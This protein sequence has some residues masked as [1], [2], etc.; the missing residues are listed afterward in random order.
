MTLATEH[1]RGAHVVQFYDTDDALVARVADHLA[2][3]LRDGEA[4]VIVA[5][6]PHRLAF[7]TKMAGT[8]DVARA[9]AEGRLVSLDAADTMAGFLSGRSPDPRR[10]EATIGG[11]LRTAAAEGRPLRVFGEMVALLWEAGQVTAAME[12]ESLWNGLAA[13]VPFS[14]FCAY[15]ASTLGVD[16]IALGDLCG[17]HTAVVGGFPACAHRPDVRIEVA[18]RRFEGHLLSPRA[19]RRFAVDALSRCGWGSLTDDASVVVGELAAN[20]VVHARTPFTV[21]LSSREGRLTVAVRDHSPRTPNLRDPASLET[22]GRGLRLVAGVSA[23]WGTELV[24][25]GK[26]VWAELA[27]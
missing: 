2:D 26:V 4:A 15:R 3:G 20:A 14:L 9:K 23:N 24:P 7:E 21:T 1:T 5:T 6:G 12:V 8:L 17:L 27:P 25:A 18:S 19:A 22:H 10:F 11:L 13:R 16:A